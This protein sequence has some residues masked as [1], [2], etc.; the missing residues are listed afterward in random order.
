MP[1]QAL[2][3]RGPAN[4]PK[5][6]GEL[7][8]FRPGVQR[9]A[10]GAGL[11]SALLGV[12]ACGKGAPPPAPAPA[13]ALSQP[14]APSASS[15]PE[16]IQA[17]VVYQSKGR[18]D[19]FRQPRVET[20]QQEPG[21]NLKLT[22]I[23]WGSRYHYALVES[24]SEPDKWYVI[25]ENSIVNSAKVLKINRNKVIF[26]VKTKSAQG[27]PLTRAVEIHLPADR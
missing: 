8:P 14:V 15:S 27:K 10:I 12:T 23:V 26:E 5:P 17:H 7:S 13:R 19:P 24:P 18:R 22:G 9:L 3:E 11:L 6:S 21:V 16:G 20:A 1:T 4:L 25:R 2:V